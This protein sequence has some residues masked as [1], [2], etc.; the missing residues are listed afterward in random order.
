VRYAKADLW[1]EFR[2]QSSETIGAAARA[3]TASDP[4]NDEWVMSEAVPA[5]HGRCS[6]F[7]PSAS[8]ARPQR[9]QDQVDPVRFAQLAVVARTAR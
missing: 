8:S 1:P 3:N 6:A 9:P 2:G 7:V 5:V 4:D